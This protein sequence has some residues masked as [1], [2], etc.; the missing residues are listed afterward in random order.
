MNFNFFQTRS[1]INC[2]FDSV[3]KLY[4]IIAI[5][6][7]ERLKAGEKG[8]FM[9]LSCKLVSYLS[10]QSGH[11][12]ASRR[13]SRNRVQKQIRM[14]QKSFGRLLTQ[15]FHLSYICMV[16]KIITWVCT[17]ILFAF[18]HFPETMY[19]W[20]DHFMGKV[21]SIRLNETFR[22]G[23]AGEAFSSFVTLISLQ[24]EKLIQNRAFSFTGGVRL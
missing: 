3:I 14:V 2:E 12:W 22:A 4:K 18:K 15:A 23:Q 11:V 17:L 19:F 24:T 21:L 8:R 6:I 1:F 13:V 16:I 9:P 10:S 20:T 5:F 7:G